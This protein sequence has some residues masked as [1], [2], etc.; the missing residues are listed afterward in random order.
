M[1]DRIDSTRH[2]IEYLAACERKDLALFNPRPASANGRRRQ[3]AFRAACRELGLAGSEYDDPDAPACLEQLVRAIRG[4]DAVICVD[5]L[6]AV[7]LLAELHQRGVRIP[8]DVYVG[9][10]GDSLLS[11]QARPPLTTVTLDMREMAR[12]AI[13]CALYLQRHPQ[14]VSL[15]C[16]VANR[17]IIRES[18]ALRPFKRGRTRS[19]RP[20]VHMKQAPEESRPAPTE[21]D[22][23]SDLEQ[24][25]AQANDLDRAILDALIRGLTCRKTAQSLFV[26]ESTVYYRLDRLCRLAQVQHRDDLL[27]LLRRYT[28]F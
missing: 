10:F 12:Q 3:D 22:K 17:L 21:L 20:A 19:G 5:D 8:E 9:S 13:Y 14:V 6:A 15:H 2:L 4:H 7:Y 28:R 11:R 23:L 25:L 1:P 16:L 27:G 24:C 18:T 26:A